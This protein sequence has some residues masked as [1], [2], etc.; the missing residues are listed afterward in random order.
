MTTTEKHSAFKIELDKSDDMSNVPSF[1]PAEIDYWLN[2]AQIMLINQ[3][4]TGDNPSKKWFESSQKRISDLAGLVALTTNAAMTCAGSPSTGT[5]A[6]DFMYF[7][8]GDLHYKISASG[9]EEYSNVIPISHEDARMFKRTA[10][11]NPII[12][13]PVM[14]RDLSGFKIYYDT[15]TI[16]PLT[17]AVMSFDYRYIKT[18]STINISLYPNAVSEISESAQKELVSLAVF[19][20]IEN[21]ESTRINTNSSILNIQE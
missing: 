19:L 9:A 2:K 5:V 13:T 20:A 4:F 11:N 14:V 21:I 10:N 3:K 8:D 18:P 12:V 1:V 16:F 15:T 6:S 7:I 17:G